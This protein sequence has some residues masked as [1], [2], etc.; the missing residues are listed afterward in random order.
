MMRPRIRQS[1]PRPGIALELSRETHQDIAD[2]SVECWMIGRDI[3]QPYDLPLLVPTVLSTFIQRIRSSEL[4]CEHDSRLHSYLLEFP[5]QPDYELVLMLNA[6]LE[7]S[8]ATLSPFIELMR[9]APV[10]GDLPRHIRDFALSKGRPDAYAGHLTGISCAGDNCR[11][12]M[13]IV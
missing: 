5:E 11:G 4:Y 8:I 7:E 9:D 6:K 2:A 10:G 3:S 1:L 12:Q 13:S